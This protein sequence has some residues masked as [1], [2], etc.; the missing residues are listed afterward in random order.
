MVR[1]WR[2][3]IDLLWVL[4][5]KEIK[6][7]YKSSVLGY[8]W[9]VLHPLSLSLVFYFAVKLVLR[10]PMENFVPF[11]VVGLFSWQWFSNSLSSCAVCLLGNASLIKKVLFPRYLIPMSAVLNDLF[12]FLMSLPVI[13]F[14]LLL[15]KIYPS[16][17]WAYGIPLLLLA[18]F[19]FTY[20]LGLMV[21]AINVF[22]RDLE[23][24]VNIGLNILFYLTP[25]IYPSRLIPEKIYPYIFLNPLFPLIE[26]WRRLFLEGALDFFLLALSFLWGLGSLCLGLYLFQRFSQRF[27]EVV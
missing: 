16:L 4:T 10:I 5:V 11:L 12:H 9:S 24:F 14:I 23:R 26:N 18:Q 1:G 27:A 17:P 19:S 6:V 7:K 21:S 20:G 2:Y 22:F 25:I 13:G 15:F 8:L 3:Y